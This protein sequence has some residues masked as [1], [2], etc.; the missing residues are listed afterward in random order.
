MTDT[1]GTYRPGLESPY[2]YAAAITPNDAVDLTNTTRAIH[3]GTA[4]SLKVTT[5]GGSTVTF[6]TMAVGYHPLR[7]TRV[8]AAG[9]TATNIT[10]LY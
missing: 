1:F 4:G 3:I 10:G 5:V 7:L 6:A 2:E 9:S 8:W